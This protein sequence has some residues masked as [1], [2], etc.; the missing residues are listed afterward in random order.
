VIQVILAQ[1]LGRKLSLRHVQARQ[2][3]AML[4]RPG[5]LVDV[6]LVRIHR[7]C[8]SRALAQTSG[9][10]YTSYTLSKSVIVSTAEVRYAWPSLDGSRTRRSCPALSG[11]RDEP[12]GP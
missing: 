3:R 4:A 1:Q 6:G 7:N 9:L 5:E 2:V 10:C 8:P 12:R 11:P